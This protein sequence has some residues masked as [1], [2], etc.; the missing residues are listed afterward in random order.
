[1]ADASQIEI[2]ASLQSFRF[3]EAEIRE[4]VKGPV[5]GDLVRRAIR[6]TNQAKQ[7]AS[8][9]PPSVPGYGPSVRTGLLRGSITWRP[10]IDARGAYV[11]V[12]S[13][14]EYAAFVELGTVYMEPRP[15]LRP[16]LEAARSTI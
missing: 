16:A 10:G 6:V 2:R 11:D 5:M 3:H 4:L 12:G 15:Y 9:P 1:M 7:N 14:V 8:Q 13:A